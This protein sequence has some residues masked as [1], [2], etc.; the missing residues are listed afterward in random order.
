MILKCSPRSFNSTARLLTTKSQC[1]R[2]SVSFYFLIRTGGRHSLLLVW[3]LQLSRARRDITILYFCSVRTMKKLQ[4]N[5]RSPSKCKCLI[6][7]LLNFILTFHTI[8][9]QELKTKYDG[10]LQKEMTGPM[11]EVLSKVFKAL[12]NRKITIPGRFTG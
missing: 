1:P 5:Y 9:R 12:V 7:I 8:F 2:F 11:F 3:I 10:R 6:L 4:L